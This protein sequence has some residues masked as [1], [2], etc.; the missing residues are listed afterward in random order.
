MVLP[1]VLLE[2][3]ET[4]SHGNVHEIDYEARTQDL[5]AIPTDVVTINDAQAVMM[6]T[7]VMTILAA[8][9]TCPPMSAWYRS[10]RY[11]AA[12]VIREMLL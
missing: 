10:V 1:E 11:S 4:E 5:F 6:M 7:I 12:S 3:Q 8:N 2:F 9:Q